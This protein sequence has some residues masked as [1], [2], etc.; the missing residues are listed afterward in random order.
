LEA[1]PPAENRHGGAPRGERPASWD[2][3]HPAGCGPVASHSRDKRNS[4]PV[5]A[6][7]T[8]L[9]SGANGSR[10][11]RAQQRAAGTNNTALF[12]IVNTTT[13]NG[14]LRAPRRRTPEPPPHPEEGAQRLSRRMGGHARTSCFETLTAFAPQHE[15]AKAHG[16]KSLRGRSFLAK[17]THVAQTQQIGAEG[18]NGDHTI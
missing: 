9:R 1:R 10:P 17:R 14:S 5:G 15:V 12:D 2:A 16:D 11:T 7:P 3:P 4:A 18:E 6:P 8:P 13:A